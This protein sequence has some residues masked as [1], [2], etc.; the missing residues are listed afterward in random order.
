MREPGRVVGSAVA[1]LLPSGIP[2]PVASL[3]P[4]ETPS[5]VASLLPSETPSPVASL[6]PSETA[7]TSSLPTARILTA[8][9]FSCC[10]SCS[11]S[12]SWR[13]WPTGAGDS[14]ARRPRVGRGPGRSVRTTIPSSST[15]S[16]TARIRG[17]PWLAH[18]RKAVRD[19]GCQFGQRIAGLGLQALETDLGALLQ[20]R[21]ERHLEHGPAPSREVVGNLVLVDARAA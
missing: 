3:L 2:S 15:G 5:P 9:R 6:L 13:D 11:S 1:S 21:I 7:T 17:E 10:S 12:S 18:C 20:V 14:C 8:R 4:S 16:T 19:C